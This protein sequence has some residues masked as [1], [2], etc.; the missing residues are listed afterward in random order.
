MIKITLNKINKKNTKSIIKDILEKYLV[1][2][3]Y[4]KSNI[5]DFFI[6]LENLSKDLVLNKREKYYLDNNNSNNNI[7]NI[8]EFFLQYFDCI[9]N[10]LNKQLDFYKITINDTDKNHLTKKIFS[11]YYKFLIEMEKELEEDK[12]IFFIDK[13]DNNIKPYSNLNISIEKFETL[14]INSTN[15]NLFYFLK[16]KE[17]FE[18]FIQLNSKSN[19]NIKINEDM[20]LNILNIKEK[21]S[22]NDLTKDTFNLELFENYWESL[23]ILDKK[24]FLNKMVILNYDNKINNKIK[25][26]LNSFFNQKFDIKDK[27]TYYLL[28][29]LKRNFV[30]L[31]NADIKKVSKNN[32]CLNYFIETNINILDITKLEKI[33]ITFNQI[34][35]TDIKT[36][37]IPL[38]FLFL[39]D[40]FIDLIN[41]N[42]N[43]YQI[44]DFLSIQYFNIYYKNNLAIK[45]ITNLLSEKISNSNID[46][47]FN[48][49][50]DKNL[51]IELNKIFTTFDLLIENKLKNLNKEELL[52]FLNNI[53]ELYN[54]NETICN[55]IFNNKNFI[56]LEEAIKKDFLLNNFKKL[57]LNFN[58]LIKYDYLINHYL[59]FLYK[60][61]MVYF[62]Y[63]TNYLAE[64]SINKIISNEKILNNLSDNVIFLIKNNFPKVNK[65]IKVNLENNNISINL[66]NNNKNL[67]FLFEDFLSMEE[68]NKFLLDHINQNFSTENIFN[69]IKPF[70][71]STNTLTYI[72]ENK[73][74]L[75]KKAISF[76]NP[77]YFN[78]IDFLKLLTK[79]NQT[80]YYFIEKTPIKMLNNNIINRIIDKP[81]DYSKA[82]VEKYLLEMKLINKEVKL[83]NIIKQKI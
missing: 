31:N 21:F 2:F 52:Y 40:K 46:D 3:N 65:E 78:T 69:K 54:N 43:K 67:F 15:Q 51:L 71:L 63:N 44:K 8:N 10:L 18:K 14:N 32:D 13:I 22:I 1:K 20:F 41:E 42:L 9:I 33:G 30:F 5:N 38:S 11:Y 17:D 74:I 70:Y 64:F 76:L 26:Q 16:N 45:N 58:D 81:F 24:D 61:K 36:K 59:F 56:L 47:I 28:I 23:N 75:D 19:F 27:N 12:F 53:K 72:F 57:N 60:E 82:I 79:D 55:I 35:E 50:N 6:D 77:E 39:N 25:K 29:L 7:E 62:N 68:K 83:K 80:Y 48:L 66:I 37:K 49:L 34:K 4:N 73:I